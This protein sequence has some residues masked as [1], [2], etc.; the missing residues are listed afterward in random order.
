[1]CFLSSEFLLLALD[2]V[3]HGQDKDAP[4]QPGHDIPAKGG[5]HGGILDAG[6][7]A[8]AEDGSWMLGA[9][10][11]V[12]HIDN[13]HVE[14]AED[15]QDG[16]KC[17]HLRSG[18]KAAEQQVADVD[19]PENESGCEACVPCPPDAPGAAAPD[20]KSVVS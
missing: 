2:V 1:M 5:Q 4:G 18:G 13:R 8:A 12:G 10:P 19:K 11:A 20:R 3:A 9:P 16:S 15:A 17:L 14:S 6:V 7:L